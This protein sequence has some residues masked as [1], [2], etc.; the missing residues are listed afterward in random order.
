MK[1]FSVNDAGVFKG[2]GYIP[3]PAGKNLFF[4]IRLLTL[5]DG[6]ALRYLSYIGD[7][8]ARRGRTTQ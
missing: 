2:L 7:E 5:K 4:I 8:T 1:K 6:K 3:T